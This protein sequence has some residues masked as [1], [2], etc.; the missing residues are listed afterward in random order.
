MNAWDRA[1]AGANAA[2]LR[3]FG[4]PV[5]WTQAPS[6]PIALTGIVEKPQRDEPANGPR[7]EIRIWFQGSDLLSPQKGNTMTYN[8]TVYTV[9]KVW[10]DGSGGIWVNGEC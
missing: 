2:Q 4:E 3:T 10:P 1:V 5:I 9:I 7:R 8:G 6:A